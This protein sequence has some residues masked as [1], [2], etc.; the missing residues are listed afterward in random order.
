MYD[1]FP[2][3]QQPFGEEVV[4]APGGAAA[5]TEGTGPSPEDPD[6]SSGSVYSELV[7]SGVP[8]DVL[9]TG[10]RISVFLFRLSEGEKSSI[11]AEDKMMWR[12]FRYKHRRLEIMKSRGE[13]L[14]DESA[15][16]S[17]SNYEQFRSSKLAGIQSS[18]AGF[19]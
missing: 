3:Q 7:G 2:F 11:S 6:Q 17:A 16:E 18:Q 9:V 4:V 14:N 8:F 19:F 1:F 10:S 5:A 13:L 15:T 12:K